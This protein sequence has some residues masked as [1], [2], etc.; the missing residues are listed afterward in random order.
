MRIECKT[1]FLHDT[2]R[3]TAGDIF[4]VSDDLG[5][6][7]VKN[8]WAKQFGADQPAAAPSGHVDLQINSST[9]GQATEGVTTNG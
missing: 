2:E 8:G 5:S 4:T 9:H 7:F 3:F 1:T 6:Y